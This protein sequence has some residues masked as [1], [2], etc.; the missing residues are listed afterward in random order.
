MVQKSLKYYLRTIH[1]KLLGFLHDILK[2]TD[3]AYFKQ[4]ESIFYQYKSQNRASK[5]LNQYYTFEFFAS[6]EEL[7]NHLHFDNDIAFSRK[8]SNIQHCSYLFPAYYGLVC[9]NHFI[10][11]GE[12]ESFTTSK[13][14]FGYLMNNGAETADGFY[15]FYNDHIGKFHL[16][17]E[18]YAGIT[19]AEILSLAIRIFITEPSDSLKS[20]IHKLANSMI[21][22]KS[23]GG[24][25]IKT[26]EGFH[27]IEEYPGTKPSY[28]LNGFIFCIIALLE[29][30]LNFP[31]EKIKIINEQL[32]ESLIKSLPHYKRG[33]YFKY[34]RLYATLS[35]IE[36][37]GVYVCQFKHLYLLTG[38]E[39][40]KLLFEET[41][42]A[43]NWQAFYDFYGIKRK[44][45]PLTTEP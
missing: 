6:S 4:L 35:N 12:E 26:P 22:D 8:D 44:L 31:S 38:N 1:L 15:L 45:I 36:Y 11:S 21:K 3:S 13:K 30:E 29:Y 14:Q 42:Q 41:N 16:K 10:K 43:M 7:G 25:L 24:I 23:E 34:S 19:Q 39:A 28:V 9:F 32:L 33:K 40:F 18:W 20:I 5:F 37:Q 27:W 2:K 17:G